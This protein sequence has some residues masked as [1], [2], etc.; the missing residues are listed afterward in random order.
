MRLRARLAGVLEVGH[1]FLRCSRV[2]QAMDQVLLNVLQ[3]RG[4]RL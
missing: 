4:D 3:A 1:D 2:E